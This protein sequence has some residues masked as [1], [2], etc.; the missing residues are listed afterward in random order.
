[1]RGSRRIVEAIA[2]A[3][4]RLNEIGLQ[5]L[6]QPADEHFYRIRVAVEILIVKVLDQLVRETTRPLW[7]AR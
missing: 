6:A 1:L 2:K 5:L 7:W 3:T 4:H